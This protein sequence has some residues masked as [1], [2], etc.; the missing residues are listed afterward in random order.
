ML[1]KEILQLLHEVNIEKL[2]NKNDQ[3]FCEYFKSVIKSS[4]IFI[5]IAYSLL[6][7]VL[8]LNI[9]FIKIFFLPK[10]IKL[11][12]FKYLTKFLNKIFIF[13][14]ILKFIKIYSILYNYD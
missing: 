8:F 11:C 3:G 7:I 9:I 14:D 2:S 12:Y 1:E 10:K 5:K 13:K 6:F 4:H